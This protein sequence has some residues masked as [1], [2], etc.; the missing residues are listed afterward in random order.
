MSRSAFSRQNG[1]CKPLEVEGLVTGHD[2]QL[3]C[4]KFQNCFEAAPPS[5]HAAAQEPL[6]FTSRWMDLQVPGPTLPIPSRHLQGSQLGSRLSSPGS[7]ASALPMNPCRL[8]SAYQTIVCPS[9][10]SL[11]RHVHVIHSIIGFS[12][13]QSSNGVRCTAAQRCPYSCACVAPHEAF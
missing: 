13:I 12:R 6:P 9:S 4:F 7:T 5:A 3:C 2:C 10:T 11:S 8:I 1:N